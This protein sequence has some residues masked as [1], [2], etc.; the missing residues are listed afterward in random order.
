MIT[1]FWS[2]F[3]EGNALVAQQ[4]YDDAAR[5]YNEAIRSSQ[6]LTEHALALETLYITAMRT[7]DFRGGIEYLKKAIVTDP[8]SPHFIR[9]HCALG[10]QYARIGA[11]DEALAIQ[12]QLFTHMGWSH[13]AVA[14]YNFTKELWFAG[15][16]KTFD[17]VISEVRRTFDADIK[18]VEIGSLQGMSACYMV[19]MF[20]SDQGF[21]L[22]CI[23]PEFQPEFWSNVENCSSSKKVQAI[24]AKSQDVLSSLPAGAFHLIHIDG[25]HVAPQV[26]IDGLLSM[27]LLATGGYVVFD[28]YLKEDQTKKGQPV[29][30]G[31]QAYW[32]VFAPWLEVVI[33]GRQLVCCLR[34]AIEYDQV[35]SRVSNVLNLILG[36]D[37]VDLSGCVSVEEIYSVITDEH[38]SKLFGASWGA[39]SALPVP[40][41]I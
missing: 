2:N 1:G 39:A 24:Q 31:V 22:T 13:A 36:N 17:S 35:I 16:H 8:N 28:D 11:M 10:A 9:M 4:R 5:F 19:D 25:W 21:E 40:V 38:A 30:A 32:A 18:A 15:N 7:G 33:D 23:D 37:S 27:R 12:S 20:S 34:K 14:E 3:K 41:R 26:F 29:K 6:D